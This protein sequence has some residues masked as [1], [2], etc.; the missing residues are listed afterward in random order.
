MFVDKTITGKDKGSFYYNTDV[1]SL[2]EFF[3]K[4]PMY[5]R[6]FLDYLDWKE[7][8]NL[9]KSKTHLT[10]EGYDKIL[11]IAH[12]MNSGRTDVLKSRRLLLKSEK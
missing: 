10:M 3:D 5:T 9:K 8:W 12:N 7:I 1:L 4:Y 2:I 6:K 11:N